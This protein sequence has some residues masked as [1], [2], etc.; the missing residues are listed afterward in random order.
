MVAA[1]EFIPVFSTFV[2]GETHNIHRLVRLA[3]FYVYGMFLVEH[4]THDW[5]AHMCHRIRGQLGLEIWIKRTQEQSQPHFCI[6]WLLCNSAGKQEKE[7]FLFFFFACVQLKY[8]AIL[9]FN[10]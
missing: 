8:G 1:S 6:F 10:F 9:V 4:H 2:V 7:K 5:M 3:L